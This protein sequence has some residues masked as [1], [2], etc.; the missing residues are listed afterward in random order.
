M[1][2]LS[3]G[4]IGQLIAENQSFG[5]LSH[6]NPDGDAIGS[7]LAFAELLR[8]L[9]KTVFCRNQDGVPD[10]L[11]FLPKAEDVI[12]PTGNQVKVDVLLALDCATQPRLGEAALAEF[13]AG[14]CINIDHHKTN[15][16]YGDFYYL[17]S[18]AS[19]TCQIIYEL[20]ADQGFELSEVARDC[21]YVGIATD[22][23]S[24]R[25]RGASTLVHKIASE[26]ITCGLDVAKINQ[27][28]YENT[29][30]RK[31]ELLREY[32]NTLELSPC[33]KIASWYLTMDTKSRLGI[34]PGD[35]EDLVNYMTNINSVLI[36]CSF[37]EQADQSIRVS[38]RS[39]SPH[40][41]VSK[42]AVSMGGGGHAKAAG[43]IFK[44]THLQSVKKNILRVVSELVTHF[45]KD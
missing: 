6:V 2:E 29:P 34:R 24:F 7:T 22:T 28:I 44:E 30:F 26:L 40:L 8:S 39:K 20:A 19:S 9:G 45:H 4:K 42:I 12:R 31:V 10:A 1:I 15:T 11:S 33:K 23:D 14:I 32:L 36:A 35:T 38:L 27:C 43:I 21:I 41:D 25:T 18:T 13:D 5:I 37:E 16:L 17:D 3:F